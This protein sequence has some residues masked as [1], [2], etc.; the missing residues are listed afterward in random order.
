MANFDSFVD[1]VSKSLE[2]VGSAFK[3][4][5][6]TAKLKNEMNSKKR[7]MEKYYM[8]LG[9]AFYENNK[10]SDNKDITAINQLKEEIE[11]IQSKIDIIKGEKK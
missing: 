4:F 9:K 1:T 11:K 3:D 10:E 7:M 5:G 8:S 6:D 2:E